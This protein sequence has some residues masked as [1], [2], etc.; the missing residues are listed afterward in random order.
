MEQKNKI[1]SVQELIDWIDNE[2]VCHVT[3]QD[4]NCFRVEAPNNADVHIWVKVNDNINDIISDTAKQLE[5][6]DADERFMELW[7]KEFAEHN[8]FL[9]SHFIRMLQ[10]D[11][12]SFSGV[13]YRLRDFFGEKKY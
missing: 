8:H 6:F 5:A 1:T 9:P 10:E 4:K 11:E 13:A 3:E 7:S 2:D 12:E